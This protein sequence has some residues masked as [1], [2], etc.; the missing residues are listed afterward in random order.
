[1]GHEWIPASNQERKARKD[2]L[3]SDFYSAINST[4]VSSTTGFFKLVGLHLSRHSW[5]LPESSSKRR[6]QPQLEFEGLT[7]LAVGFNHN[8][9]VR[10]TVHK[11][12][13][14]PAWEQPLNS[15]H[16]TGHFFYRS[17]LMG[18]A[19]EVSSVINGYVAS[20]RIVVKTLCWSW[21]SICV[22]AIAKDCFSQMRYI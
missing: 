20:G 13:G 18:T 8:Q 6:R 4:L 15:N 7:F 10:V 22:L 14:G 1:M 21:D 17:S 3:K 5:E 9:E 19:S 16:K 11:G 2:L 12:V